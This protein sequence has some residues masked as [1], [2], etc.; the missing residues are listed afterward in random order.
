MLMVVMVLVHED[1]GLACVMGEEEVE[2]AIEN[3]ETELGWCVLRLLAETDRCG[4]AIVLYH[5]PI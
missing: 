5:D 3:K 4:D 2:Q 1:L